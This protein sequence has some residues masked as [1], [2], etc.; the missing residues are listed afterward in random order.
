A[1][2]A[3]VADFDGEVVARLPLDVER[4]VVGVGQLVGAV[5]DAERDGLAA[6]VDGGEVG[7]IVAE[8]GGPGVGGGGEELRAVRVREVALRGCGGGDGSEAAAAVQRESVAA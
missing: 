6:L 5:I 2:V 4:V 1:E 3:D 8:V 7:Q